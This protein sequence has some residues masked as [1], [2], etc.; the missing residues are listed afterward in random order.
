MN[1]DVTYMSGAGNLFSV[2]NNLDGSLKQSDGVKLAP[3]LCHK[4][5]YNDFQSEG[6]MFLEKSSHG[7]TF[8]C[9]FFNPDGSTGMMCGNGGRA[10]VRFAQLQNQIKDNLNIEFNMSG[11][12]YKAKIIE[13]DIKL[14][15]PAP[16]QRPIKKSI[17]INNNK[18]EIYYANTGTHHVCINLNDHY[19][20]DFDINKIGR[21]IRYHDEFQPEGTNVNFYTI[22]NENQLR[23]YEKGVEA[24]TGA[25]GTGAIATALTLNQ[26]YGIE[27]PISLFPTSG[28]KISVDILGKSENIEK[29]ILIGPAKVLYECSINLPDNLFIN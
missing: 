5:E 22:G 2:L 28:E 7:N 4:N 23:T 29:T 25:C 13:N 20:D 6:L 27:F 15:L 10:I 14:Y 16:S 26:V 21:E 9:S 12:I 3:I 17:I 11:D 18:I 19:Q 1:L 24:E 8:N